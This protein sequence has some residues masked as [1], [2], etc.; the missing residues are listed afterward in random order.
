MELF[1]LR[2][3]FCG[4]VYFGL[5]SDLSWNCLLSL[6]DYVIVTRMVDLILSQQALVFNS[7]QLQVFLKTLWEKE[8]LLITSNFS[9]THSVF[10]PMWGTFCHLNEI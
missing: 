4:S 10:L 6:L 3:F 1:K 2:H 8:K 9:F 7:R 5:I